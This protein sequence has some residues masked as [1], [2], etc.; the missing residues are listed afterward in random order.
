MPAAASALKTQTGA[1]DAQVQD[2]AAAAG[3]TSR[4]GASTA[5]A[6]ATPARGGSSSELY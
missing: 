2:D 1:D 5:T 4:A 3:M 6:P